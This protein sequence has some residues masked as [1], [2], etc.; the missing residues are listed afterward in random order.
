MS[1]SVEPRSSTRAKTMTGTAVEA[2]SV[3]TGWGQG[4]Q[5]LPAD[6]ARAAAGRTVIP[7]AARRSRASGSGGPPA[8]VSWGWRRSMP[9]C[10]QAGSL[11]RS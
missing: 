6:A 5:A 7:L 8:S 10:G 2:V 9:S 3:L 1:L 4:V 11:V